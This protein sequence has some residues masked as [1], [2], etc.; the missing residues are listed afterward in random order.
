MTL[1][2]IVESDEVTAQVKTMVLWTLKGAVVIGA[3]LFLEKLLGF[4]FELQVG[5]G[6]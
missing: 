6:L 1:K 4:G 5:L 3:F 2:D